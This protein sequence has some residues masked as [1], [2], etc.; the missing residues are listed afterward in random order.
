MKK[1]KKKHVKKSAKRIMVFGVVSCFICIF[2]L[3]TIAKLAIAVVNKTHELN[4]LDEK[5][6]IV[7]KDGEEKNAFIDKWENSSEFRVSY[8]REKQFYSK[9]NEYIFRFFDE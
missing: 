5:L 1:I 7:I 6:A 4:E 8:I 3:F 9:D 2:Q